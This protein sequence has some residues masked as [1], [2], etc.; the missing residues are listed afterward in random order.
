MSISGMGRTA[1]YEWLGR[2]AL[3]SIKLG[4]RVLIDVE[5]GLAWLATLPPAQIAA[6]K[7]KPPQS[8]R[9]ADP[10]NVAVASPA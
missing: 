2:G 9:T 1:T 4:T 10:S 5:A 8:P 6:P 7:A 3:H